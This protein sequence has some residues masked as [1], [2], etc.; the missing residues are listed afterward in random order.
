VDVGI[1][2]AG[3]K[4]LAAQVFDGG[5]GRQGGGQ[6]GVVAGGLDLAVLDQQ[7][8]VAVPLGG[9]LVEGGIVG[10]IQQA[11]AVGLQGWAHG[12]SSMQAAWRARAQA[13]DSVVI[14]LEGMVVTMHSVLR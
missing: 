13:V 2:E 7:Q 1:D 5:A 6:R 12:V 14:I 3:A 10:E 11:G 8:A 9:V 4:D